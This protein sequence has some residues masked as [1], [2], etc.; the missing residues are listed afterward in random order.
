[1]MGQNIHHIILKI[2]K[3]K[4]KVFQFVELSIAIGAAIV[5]KKYIKSKKGTKNEKNYYYS[6]NYIQYTF[7]S[8]M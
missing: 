7:Y 1:M 2:D 6:N 4:I 8:W 5:Y 3:F